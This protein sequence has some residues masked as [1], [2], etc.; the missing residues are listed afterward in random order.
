MTTLSKSGPTGPTMQHIVEVATAPVH[1]SY[2]QPSQVTPTSSRP[3]LPS[4]PAHPPIS[5][6][7]TVFMSA[8]SLMDTPQDTS[9]IPPPA[10]VT[11]PP[12][13]P[14]PL[15][16]HTLGMKVSY[17]QISVQFCVCFEKH[18][19]MCRLLHAALSLICMVVGL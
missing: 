7:P 5:Q 1:P 4:V 6:F 16:T 17:F 18:N 10:I 3:L 19:F 12:A 9:S 8:P 15:T 13:L 11:T 14:L 2:S